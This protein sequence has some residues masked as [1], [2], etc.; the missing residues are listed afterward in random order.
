MSQAVAERVASRVADVSA[1]SVEGA[2]VG[3]VGGD[4]PDGDA[5]GAQRRREV[6][7][8]VRV[9]SCSL[10]L[11]VLIQHVYVSLWR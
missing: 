6:G 9:V 1:E 4:L 8:E 5:Q 11:T 7:R 3:I 2:D 10:L